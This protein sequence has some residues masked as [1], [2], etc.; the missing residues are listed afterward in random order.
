MKNI[1]VVIGSN[2]GDEGKGLMT[3]YFCRKGEKVLNIRFNGGAQAGHTVVTPDGKRHVFS[4]IGAG[5]FAGADTYLSKFFIV[6]P[7]LFMKEYS[8]LSN[9]FN[10]SPQII[11]SRNAV[12]TLPCDMLINQLVE[13]T[14]NKERHGSCGVGINETL[15]RSSYNEFKIQFADIHFE[16]NPE[17]PRNISYTRS[18]MVNRIRNINKVYVSKR[19]EELGI[20]DIPN[21]FYEMLNNENLIYNYIDDFMSMYRICKTDCYFDEYDTA[22]FEGAQGLL[23]DCN[24]DDYFPHLTPS[25]TGMKNVRELLKDFPQCETEICYVTRSYFTRHGAGRFKS[26]NAE[27]Q[28]QYNL[29]DKTNCFN[30]YQRNFRYGYFDLDEFIYTIKNDFKYINTDEKISLA[31]THL[32]ETDDKII[33]LDGNICSEELLKLIEISGALYKSYGETSKNIGKNN[34]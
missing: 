27:V 14:R 8:F 1:Y 30:E 18:Y 17:Y 10:I 3:D 28:K 23:L 15:V 9:K 21:D 24:R 19:L 5:T 32:D 33:C 26:E 13:S 6:N 22:V 11:V 2:F 34:Y 29:K 16:K 7:M 4:H 25:D 12:V 31:V 20:K